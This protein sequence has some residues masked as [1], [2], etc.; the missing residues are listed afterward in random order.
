[1]TTLT[2]EQRAARVRQQ[3][4]SDFNS[5]MRRPEVKLLLSMLPGSTQPP[6]LVTTLMRSAFDAGAT[7]GQGVFAGEMVE[8]M[9]G[10]SK[11]KE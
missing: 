1:M 5:W 2:P 4:D 10:V 6:E 3:S 9:L 7:C 8:M 11:K